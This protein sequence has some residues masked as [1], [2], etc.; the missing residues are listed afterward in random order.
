MRKTALISA[1]LSAALALP[2]CDKFGGTEPVTDR[3]F[4]FSAEYSRSVSGNT[5][6]LTLDRGDREKEYTLTYLVDR[7][8]SVVLTDAGGHE[9]FSGSTVDFT[10]GQVVCYLPQMLSAGEHRIALTL[11]TDSFRRETDYPFTVTHEP[12]IFYSE[13][14]AEP[15]SPFSSLLLSIDEGPKDREYRGEVSVDGEYIGELDFSADFS[16][17]PIVR[18]DL[19]L[20]RPGDHEVSV[21]LSWE[22][23]TWAVSRSFYEPNRHPVIDISLGQYSSKWGNFTTLTL[24]KNPYGLSLALKD[25]VVVKG[26]CRYHRADEEAAKQNA[27][28]TRNYIV[29]KELTEVNVFD[30]C[31]PSDGWYREI[32]KPSELEITLANTKIQNTKW[33]YQWDEVV[34]TYWPV[35]VDDGY[36]NYTVESTTHHITLDFEKVK[37]LTVR[38]KNKDISDFSTLVINGTQMNGSLEYPL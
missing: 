27:H 25:S 6:T 11:S 28:M 3:S 4:D 18:V 31:V 5:L 16:L 22:D 37:G 34:Q 33:E 24:E 32:A 12:V 17:R 13:V 9:I 21:L 35:I 8:R 15:S 30:R 1:A 29:E 19:P 36:S 14:K 10:S 38:V 2:S 7:D 20:L 26:T 23:Q